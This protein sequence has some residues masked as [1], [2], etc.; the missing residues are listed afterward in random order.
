M[1]RTGVGGWPR[2]LCTR[3]RGLTRVLGR[4][5]AGMEAREGPRHR[6]QRRGEG[7]FTPLPL[8]GRFERHQH[9]L[10]LDVCWRAH[11]AVVVNIDGY[12]GSAAATQLLVVAVRYLGSERCERRVSVRCGR[13]VAVRI[14]LTCMASCECWSDHRSHSTVH[15]NVQPL[16]AVGRRR[17]GRGPG[18][19]R[20]HA[21]RWRR[22][23]GG[24]A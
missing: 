4:T 22:R 18:H 6:A 2:E 3:V 8:G 24:R 23:D 20:H 1:V 14:A 5:I 10:L 15:L 19:W 21:G 12:A 7:A 16:G 13:V 9:R 17:I 11:R